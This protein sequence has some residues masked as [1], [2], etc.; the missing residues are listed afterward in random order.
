MDRLPGWPLA[1]IDFAVVG[2]AY[3]FVFYDIS[4]IG[5][6]MPEITKQFDLSP[7]AVDFV[8]VAIGL[9]GYIVGSNIIGALS[10]RKGR[11][12]A[13]VTSLLISGIG[14]LGCAFATGLISLSFWRFV[15]G[16]GV[17]AALNLASTYIGELSPAAHRGRISVS[18]FMVGIIGQAI[19]PFVALALVPNFTIGWRLLFAIGAVIGLIGVVFGL[20]LPE[21]PRWLVEQGRLEEAEA[22]IET[23]ESRFSA[24]QLSKNP[25]VPDVAETPESTGDGGHRESATR[26]LLH[27]RHGKTVLAMVSLWFLWYI[28]NYGFLGDAATLFADNGLSIGDSI[29][30]LA[31]GA[32]GY[33]TGAGI[34]LVTAD[35]IERRYLIFSS[36]VVWLMGMVLIATLANSAVVTTGAF[37][38]AVALGSFLQ[39]A[40]TY[41]AER[42]PTRLRARG[43]ALAD[44]VGHAGGAVGALL[45]PT[46]VLRTSFFTG[47]VVIGITGLL[48]GFIALFG[49]KSSGRSLEDVR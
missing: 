2:I 47:F 3:F 41:T 29:L 8:A 9:I 18:A 26:E 34:M 38:A 7:G 33:P 37:L 28:G 25:P 31:V 11:R 46:L 48:A 12:T 20:R 23:M 30:Y 14:S 5:F 43:F 10:D 27:G 1:R 6:A 49:P 21:S 42:F 24:E 17:G 44:G 19:T 15:T 13:F 32:I 16:A 39:M 40:Y 45:L 22:V 35:R 4:D 36:T